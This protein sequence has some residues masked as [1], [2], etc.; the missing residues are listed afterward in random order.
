MT[1][2][3]D[4]C[5]ERGKSRQFALKSYNYSVFFVLKDHIISQRSIDRSG[6]IVFAQ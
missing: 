5:G 1:L 6:G 3:H 2:N 4:M